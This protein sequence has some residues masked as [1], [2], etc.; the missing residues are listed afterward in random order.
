MYRYVCYTCYSV[1]VSIKRAHC[2]LHMLAR[3]SIIHIRMFTV[4]IGMKAAFCPAW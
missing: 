1:C 3:P 2:K 4:L